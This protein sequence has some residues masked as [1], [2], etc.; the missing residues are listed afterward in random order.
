[1]GEIITQ[2]VNVFIEHISSAAIHMKLRPDVGIHSIN[3]NILINEKSYVHRI[4][5]T[6]EKSTV[7]AVR[8]SSEPHD[9]INLSPYLC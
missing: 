9:S 3:H 2:H 4:E 8:K 6:K 5:M 1:M 7:G